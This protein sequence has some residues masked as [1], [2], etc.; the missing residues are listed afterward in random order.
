MKFPFYDS[1]TPALATTNYSIAVSVSVCVCVFLQ[2]PLV[3]ELQQQQRLH[4][5]HIRPES[6]QRCRVPLFGVHNAHY[7]FACGCRCRSGGVA[8]GN[9]FCRTENAARNVVLNFMLA[10]R[11]RCVRCVRSA[12][13]STPRRCEGRR[14]RRRR[15]RCAW[16]WHTTHKCILTDTHFVL[17]NNIVRLLF[18][19]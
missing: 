1:T 6:C 9:C 2:R 18:A 12:R 10:V 7:I 4:L 8:A 17:N 5:I 15:L 19:E 14:R 3:A 13:S 16:L 11:V